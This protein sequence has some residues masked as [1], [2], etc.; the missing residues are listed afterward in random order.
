MFRR[1]W[2]QPIGETATFALIESS[3]ALPIKRAIIGLQETH[4]G[5][6]H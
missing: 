3:D 6:V 2:D 4:R 5:P 1:R